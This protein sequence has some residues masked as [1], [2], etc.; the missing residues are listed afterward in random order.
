MRTHGKGPRS[1]AVEQVMNPAASRSRSLDDL[2]GAGEQRRWHLDAERLRGLE[3]DYQLEPSG[4]LDGEFGGLSAFK[5]TKHVR[6]F[7]QPHHRLR[8][9][10]QIGPPMTN[11]APTRVGDRGDRVALFDQPLRKPVVG[12]LGSASADRSN[13]RRAAAPSHDGAVNSPASYR[14]CGFFHL[15]QIR[16]YSFGARAYVRETHG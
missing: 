9:I 7:Q 14:G 2:V 15:T 11:P 4:L 6:L 8:N 12:S 10:R 13:V 1:R 5:Y 16:P 3:I